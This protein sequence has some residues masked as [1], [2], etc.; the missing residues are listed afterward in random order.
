[1]GTVPGCRSFDESRVCVRRGPLAILLL[2]CLTLVL[3][4]SPAL[5]PGADA[6]SLKPGSYAG[7]I[8]PT[9]ASSSTSD[10][11]IKFKV[12]R[13]GTKIKRLSAKF[14]YGCWIGGIFT[15]QPYRFPSFH[16]GPIKVKRNGRFSAR[17]V[18]DKEAGFTVK[19]SGKTKRSSRAKGSI[20]LNT[21]T[22]GNGC[23][24]DF[25]WGAKRK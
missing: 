2:A 14:F 4:A 8:H 7:K 9:D 15:L 11:V 13:S 16:K 21:T 6:K 23:G 17:D 25:T 10:T 24:R 12:T 18:V 20:S 19:F 22:K 3:S 1:M 5:V